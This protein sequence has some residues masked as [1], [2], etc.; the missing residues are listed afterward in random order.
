MSSECMMPHGLIES[1]MFLALCTGALAEDVKRKISIRFKSQLYLIFLL[2]FIKFF[3]RQATVIGP[4]PPG[5]G[6]I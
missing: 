1:N 6:V 3:N 2:S 5:T 4:T